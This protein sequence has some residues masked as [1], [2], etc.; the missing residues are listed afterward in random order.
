MF[1]L[2]DAPMRYRVTCDTR[3]GSRRRTLQPNTK[4]IKGSVKGSAQ[5]IA[6]DTTT[7]SLS[8]HQQYEVATLQI[9]GV[10]AQVIY[11]SNG[12]GDQLKG[13]DNGDRLFSGLKFWLSLYTPTPDHFKT[14]I[15]VRLNS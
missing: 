7:R 11:E 4:S 8:T 5:L 12:N 2:F 15:T 6:N 3:C 14:R 13:E 9:A 1:D 10:M